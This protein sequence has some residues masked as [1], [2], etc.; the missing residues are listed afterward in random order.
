MSS[1]FFNA[2]GSL[3]RERVGKDVWEC[4]LFWQFYDHFCA[5]SGS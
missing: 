2:V 3:S 4:G 1:L 5:M